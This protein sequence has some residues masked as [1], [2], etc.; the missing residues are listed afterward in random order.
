MGAAGRQRAQAYRPDSVVDALEEALPR[1][2]WWTFPWHLTRRMRRT[3]GATGIRLVSARH[4][5]KHL[6]TR[7]GMPYVTRRCS[8]RPIWMTRCSHAAPKS[9]ASPDKARSW[10]SICS[11]KYP[12]EVKVRAVVIGAERYD[13]ER[14]AARFLGYASHN[15]DE[16]DAFFRRPAYRSVGNIFR[17]PRAGRCGDLDLSALR[18][19]VFGFLDGV[20]YERLYV[21]MAVGWHVDHTLTHLVFEPWAHRSNLVYYEDARYCRFSD[22]TKYRLKELGTFSRRPGDASLATA[23]GIA[24]WWQ[25]AWPM[26]GARSLE[27]CDPGSSGRLRPLSLVCIC[28]G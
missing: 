26:P 27:T 6:S 21:P 3:A 16:L 10:C 19:R 12:K 2:T 9:L 15:F 17:P 1:C 18:E 13:E 5:R 14:A 28:S 4:N 20:D 25:T 23:S 11:R 7:A 22:A 24:G 8:S